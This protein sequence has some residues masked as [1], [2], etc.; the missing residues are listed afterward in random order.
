[1]NRKENRKPL[2]DDLAYG[3]DEFHATIRALFVPMGIDVDEIGEEWVKRVGTFPRIVV[4]MDQDGDPEG[5]RNETTSLTQYR[6]AKHAKP[7]R[8]P[9]QTEDGTCVYVPAVENADAPPVLVRQILTEIDEDDS[10]ETVTVDEYERVSIDLR[11]TRRQD[12]T[13]TPKRIAAALAKIPRC[14]VRLVIQGSGDGLVLPSPE[15]TYESIQGRLQG[16]RLYLYEGDTLKLDKLLNL[17]WVTLRD[18]YNA[19]FV[20]GAPSPL[21]HSESQRASVGYDWYVQLR[22]PIYKLGRRAQFR[23]ARAESRLIA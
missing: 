5:P 14:P 17:V 3:F 16:A 7:V 6:A 2:Y 19:N 10:P 20:P 8:I 1:M 13:T 4:T 21:I 18:H 15:A 23:S 12:I 9:G 22:T 11:A